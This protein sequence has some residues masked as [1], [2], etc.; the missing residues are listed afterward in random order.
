MDVLENRAG[1][2]GPHFFV[3]SMALLIAFAGGTARAMPNSV[4][5]CR[6]LANVIEQTVSRVLRRQLPN[7]RGVFLLAPR[8][9]DIFACATTAFTASRAFSR[10]ARSAGLSISWHDNELMDPGDVCLSHYIDQCYPR[11]AHNP[12]INN[13]LDAATI[14]VAW[15]TVAAG[16]QQ[17]MPFGAESDFA[18]FRPDGLSDSLARSLQITLRMQPARMNRDTNVSPAIQ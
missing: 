15:D 10:A 4:D 13:A 16:L 14:S 18:Y 2:F 7:P 12:F 3:L 17:G 9:S 1:T 5:G 6:T 8:Q 11:L